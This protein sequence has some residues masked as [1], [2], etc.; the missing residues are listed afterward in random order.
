MQIVAKGKVGQLRNRLTWW[1]E[2]GCGEYETT[3]QVFCALE[4]EMHACLQELVKN[5]KQTDVEEIATQ[6]INSED[7]QFYWCV[8]SAAFDI[9][10]DEV[11]REL[12]QKIIKLSIT[13]RGLAFASAWVEKYKQAEKKSTQRSKS[14]CKSCTLTTLCNHSVFTS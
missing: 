10:D 14:L 11:H 5:A 6:L 3:F 4:E 13:I 12:L 2:E 9:D 7:V 8:A 1:I